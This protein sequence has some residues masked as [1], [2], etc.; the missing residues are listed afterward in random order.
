MNQ[1]SIGKLL[2]GGT[3]KPCTDI[4]AHQLVH[5]TA[6][7]GDSMKPRKNYPIKLYHA[8][9]ASADWQ[10]GPQLRIPWTPITAHPKS[11]LTSFGSLFL[12]SQSVVTEV[13]QCHKW[14]HISTT[15]TSKHKM[16]NGK[17]KLYSVCA[18]VIIKD[19][20]SRMPTT[21]RLFCAV[22]RQP[23]RFL[24]HVIWKDEAENSSTTGKGKRGNCRGEK[25]SN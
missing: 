5:D 2:G 3:H 19:V 24:G 11:Q 22:R 20:L 17:T 8:T 18:H 16:K 13:G 6:M 4:Q 21:H 7:N 1:Q 25:L 14:L 12:P 15:E 10:T 9:Q 23:M